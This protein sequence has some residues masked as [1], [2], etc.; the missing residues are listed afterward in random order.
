MITEPKKAN[1][2]SK[3]GTNNQQEQQ[4]QSE[5]IPRYAILV[6]DMLDDFIHGKLRSERVKDIIPQ[7]RM[8]LNI[9]RQRKIPIFYCNDEHLQIDPEIRLWGEH[10]MKGTKGAKVIEELEPSI[11]DYI[12]PKRTYGSFDGTN[13]ERA[14]ASTY[15]G[16]G[17]NTLI[18]TGIHTHI[19]VKHTAY[20]AFIRGY[21]TIIAED[22]VNAFTEKDHL[23]GL[24]YIHNNY[25][26][27]MKKVS[28]IMKD[29]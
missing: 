14:L 23:E 22:G 13:L 4:R 7:I 5:Y 21:N 29:L 20:G 24:E 6:N 8:L 3:D 15:G 25:G 9:A 18:I 28:D 19:C 2:N 26:A 1:N 27:S 16:R 11:G 12:I 10:A 17:A